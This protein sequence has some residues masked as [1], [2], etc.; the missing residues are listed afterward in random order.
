MLFGHKKM[1]IHPCNWKDMSPC[2]FKLSLLI[3]LFN[4][5]LPLVFNKILGLKS[6]FEHF[7]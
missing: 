7:L 6:C 1:Y 5:Y 4:K 2:T 3:A